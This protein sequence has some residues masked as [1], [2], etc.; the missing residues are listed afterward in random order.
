MLLFLAGVTTLLTP[1]QT[2]PK[3]SKQRKAVIDFGFFLLEM[4]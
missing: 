4:S 1:S 2:V 3:S